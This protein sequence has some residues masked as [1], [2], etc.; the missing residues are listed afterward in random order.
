MDAPFDRGEVDRASLDATERLRARLSSSPIAAPRARP[1]SPLAWL[2]AAALFV[3]LIGMI[4]NPWFENNVRSKLPF[5]RG[6]ATAPADVAV[7][8]ARI[9]QLES[10]APPPAAPSERL[11]RTEAKIETSTDQIAR[12]AQR[13]DRLTGDV[14]TLSA[15]IAA[16]RASQQAATVTATAAADR[17]HSMLTLVLVRRAID[18]GRTLGPLDAAL[19]Q[20]FQARYPQAVTQV[21]ALGNAPVTLATLRH[22]F[23]QMRVAIGARPAASD[24]QSWWDT[25]TTTIADAVSR[26]A[27]DGP[28]DLAAAALARGDI[29]AAASQLRRLPTPRAAALS[30]WLDAADRW[31]AGDAAL[32]TLETATLLA[33]ALPPLAPIAPIAPV[34]TPIA[35]P[36]GRGE[37]ISRSLHLTDWIPKLGLSLHLDRLF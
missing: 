2:I 6:A 7:L 19:R 35:A 34:A 25:L 16:D 8:Q 14:A 13:I 18:N 17:A 30:V 29:A 32:A 9:A 12:D 37:K 27:T 15:T 33:P 26:P 20:S 23:V 1:R 5:A 28:T 31:R 22:G 36:L 11:A 10:R 3:F 24:R 4:A 21:V